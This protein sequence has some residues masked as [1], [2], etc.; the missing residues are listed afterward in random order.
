VVVGLA[1]AW[2]LILGLVAGGVTKVRPPVEDI[3]VAQS[4]FD[5]GEAGERGDFDANDIT[6]AET[7]DSQIPSDFRPPDEVAGASFDAGFEATNRDGWLMVYDDNG[8]AVAVYQQLGD[9]QARGLP[10]G[11]EDFEIDGSRAWRSNGIEGRNAVVVQ[12][13]G[14][15]YTVVG[16]ADLDDL[17]EIAAALP[18]R[19]EAAAPSWGERITDAMDG[20]LEAFSPGTD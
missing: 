3:A 11:G 7:A 10:G 4:G 1:A 16:E 6:F 5:A 18:E 8:D 14:M 19:D 9:F 15:T 12:R 13:G 17:V 2:L 20:F